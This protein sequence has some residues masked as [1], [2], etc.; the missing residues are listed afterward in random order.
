MFLP[1]I[2]LPG[3]SQKSEP[4][5]NNSNVSNTK[6]IQSSNNDKEAFDLPK[7]NVSPIPPHK[8]EGQNRYA[9]PQNLST[10]QT[11]TPSVTQNEN[12]SS[13]QQPDVKSE[14][15]IV[16]AKSVR[17]VKF[18][19]I[20]M[21]P[22]NISYVRDTKTKCGLIPIETDDLEEFKKVLEQNY[23]GS[24]SYAINY[25]GENYR[26]ERIMTT[27]GVQFNCR[28]MPTETP[29]I[30]SLGLPNPVVNQLVSL[31]QEAGLI[32]IGG[33]T[34]MGKTTTL[35]AL[36]RHYLEK[37]GGFLY[38]VED[39][40]EMPL[41]GVYHAKNGA[42]GLC[43]QTPVENERW[44]D[45]L[46]SALRSRPRYILVGEV[47]TPETASQ[48]LRAATSGHLVLTT[49]HANSVED[50]LNSM[51]K[52]A[53]G[54]GLPEM[55]VS[56]LLARSILAVIHQKL[57]GTTVLHPVIQSAFANPDLGVGDQMRSTIREGKISLGTLME[58]QAT[59][60]LQGKPLFK[61][62]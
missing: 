30:F 35:S 53:A 11:N 58:A 28:K 27:T 13:T 15:P 19:D 6:Q 31:S 34:G 54:A 26:I 2:T 29:D 7:I 1:K 46:K 51:I 12:Q 25:K 42:L 32:L 55:L 14:Q 47:R 3:I 56:D 57:V 33:P 43:K 21:T 50:A 62:Y 36:L 60:L 5:Q 48:A 41:N 37:D 40:P 8:D 22:E 17:D 23:T 59:K 24:S 18:A 10:P 20:W 39:P 45:G 16:H 9:R 4:I 38:T 44:E 61:S 49:I 52:Y